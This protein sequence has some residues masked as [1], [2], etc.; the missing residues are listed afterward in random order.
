MRQNYRYLLC[1]CTQS[2]IIAFAGRILGIVL[3]YIMCR[4]AASTDGFLRFTAK[5]IGTYKFVWQM[6]VYAVALAV[7]MVLF[8]TVP[9]WKN[10]RTP[11]QSVAK[12]GRISKKKPLWEKCFIDVILLALSAYLLY[13]YNK[14]KSTLAISVLENKSIDPVMILDNSLLYFGWHFCA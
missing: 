6:L 8:I 4:V 14:Q 5:D 2:G 7:I 1:T 11:Y 10:Q 3:G 13:N 12:R 9:V